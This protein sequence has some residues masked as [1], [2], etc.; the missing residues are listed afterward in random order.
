MNQLVLSGTATL[1]PS[2]TR[3]SCYR[4]PESDL[5]P[6]LSALSSRRNSSNQKS[7]GFLLTDRRHS[8]SWG[9]P[10][11]TIHLFCLVSL[12]TTA[13]MRWRN[14]GP[15]RQSQRLSSLEHLMSDLTEVELL[16]LRSAS[17]TAFGLGVLSRKRSS[18]VAGGCCHLRRA[19]SL[20]SFAGRRMTSERQSRGSTSCGRLHPDIGARLCPM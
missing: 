9:Q 17:K 1:V 19:A 2:G 11:T 3:S 4:G 13:T 6:C 20:R 5:S 16:W 7:F 10:P 18:I 15:A 8:G 12:S 14:R